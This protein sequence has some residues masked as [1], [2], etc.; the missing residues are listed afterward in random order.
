M[1]RALTLPSVTVPELHD[2]NVGAD[3]GGDVGADTGG[4]VGGT[5]GGGV[6]PVAAAHVPHPSPMFVV[7]ATDVAQRPKLLPEIAQLPALGAQPLKMDPSNVN[8][9]THGVP[10]GG[11][12]GP[13]AAPSVTV[14]APAH[15][16]P[17]AATGGGVG[18]GVGAD[19]GGFVGGAVG[20][21]VRLAT[22]GPVPPH[23]PQS[24]PRS[25]LRLVMEV[26]Q[27]PYWTV[28]PGKSTAQL[29]AL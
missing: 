16:D 23:D 19:T 27:K 21:G 11:T 6:G 18:G 12:V 9:K 15:G 25:E 29:F 26:G 28:R 13:P 17:V 22:P 7:P 14:L 10:A 1:E 24:R 3:T 8:G 5:V 4:F 2:N 20:G